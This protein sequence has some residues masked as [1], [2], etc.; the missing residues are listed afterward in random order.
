MIV[1]LAETDTVEDG[2]RD[3]DTDAV[4]VLVSGT[5]L[6]FAQYTGTGARPIYM[7]PAASR[8]LSQST[9]E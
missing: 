5:R 9:F 2:V 1:L 7:L 4:G 3:D 6:V 8:T